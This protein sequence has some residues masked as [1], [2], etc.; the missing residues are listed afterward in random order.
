MLLP[1]HRMSYYAIIICILIYYIILYMRHNTTVR[2]T[3]NNYYF[4]LYVPNTAWYNNSI[5]SD[6]YKTSHDYKHSLFWKQLRFLKIIY[7]FNIIPSPH[8]KSLIN[9]ILL[10]IHI[11]TTFIVIIVKVFT[12]MHF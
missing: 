9:I 11:V 4:V 12:F 6:S 1:V 7:L 10:C 8:N 5:P 3:L 2:R